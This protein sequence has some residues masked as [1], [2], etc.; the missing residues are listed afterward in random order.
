MDININD[1]E[2]IN[3]D[4]A[5]TRIGGNMALYKRLLGR[6]VE[7]NHFDALDN[8]LQSGDLDEASRQAHSLKGVSANL[9]LVKISSVALDL[10]QKIKDN[11]DYS[12]SLTELKQVF[13]TTLE[14][15]AEIMG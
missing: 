14:K 7:G 1:T 9:S 12:E 15:I 13:S 2:Y 6:F 10:E 11:L 3:L 4:D 8:A 5:L